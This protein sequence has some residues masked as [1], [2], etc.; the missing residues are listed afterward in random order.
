MTIR[1]L[2]HSV[3]SATSRIGRWQGL[4]LTAGDRDIAVPGTDSPKD[5]ASRGLAATGGRVAQAA[6]SAFQRF[7]RPF[8]PCQEAMALLPQFGPFP[9]YCLVSV[10]WMLIWKAENFDW[11]R[12]SPMGDSKID[13]T[14]CATSPTTKTAA[15]C[16]PATCRAISPASRTSPSPSFASRGA[17]TPSPKPTGTTLGG[18]R[19]PCASSS[20]RPN[21]EPHATATP[22]RLAPPPRQRSRSPAVQSEL[23]VYFTYHSKRPRYP[24]SCRPEPPIPPATAPPQRIP[25]NHVLILAPNKISPCPRGA[26]GALRGSARARRQVLRRGTL[27][28]RVTAV[29]V[30]PPQPAR[31]RASGTKRGRDGTCTLENP[32][33]HLERTTR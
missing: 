10:C 14:T 30:S 3:K 21:A 6:R 13:S 22:R 11:R 12:S 8:S 15:G 2:S 25:T 26:Q 19:T 31:M 1:A 24:P 23:P 33:A 5:A 18:P 27:D 16:E 4:H 7:R 17:S 28:S 9:N 20:T 32:G 29:Q